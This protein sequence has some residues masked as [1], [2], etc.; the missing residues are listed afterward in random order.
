MLGFSLMAY[1]ILEE[2]L[3]YIVFEWSTMINRLSLMAQLVEQQQ[4]EWK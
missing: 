2:K 1:N 3:M 4:W